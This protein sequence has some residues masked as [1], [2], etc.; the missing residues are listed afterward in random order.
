VGELA[1]PTPQDRIETRRIA[2]A[3]IEAVRADESIAAAAGLHFVRAHDP[4][5]VSVA[6]G[7]ADVDSLL[8][9]MAQEI[10]ALKAERDEAC[11]LYCDFA[12]SMLEPLSDMNRARLKRIAEIGQDRALPTPRLHD[13]RREVEED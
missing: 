8:V 9:Q 6:Y 5:F 4:G 11:S 7:V 12:G 1:T 3:V 2:S 13:G 10:E